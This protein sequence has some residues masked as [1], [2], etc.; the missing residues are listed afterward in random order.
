VKATQNNA[1]SPSSVRGALATFRASLSFANGTSTP[2]KRH[3]ALP[4]ALLT[5]L[6]LLA[7]SASSAQAVVT[8]EFLCQITGAGSATI[9]ATECDANPN[10]AENPPVL[11]GPLS[12]V[13]ALTVDSGTLW[14][15]EHLEGTGNYRVDEFNASSGAFV[16]QLAQS[17]NEELLKGIA[18]GH[19][20]GAAQL[21][22]GSRGSGVAV[23]DESGSRLATWTG[24][25]TPSGSIEKRLDVAVDSST[26]LADWAAGDVY[27]SSASESSGA[28]GVVDVFKPKPGGGEEYVSQL[29]GIEPGVPFSGPTHVTVDESNGDVFVLDERSAVDVF[30]PTAPGEYAFLRQ[31]I[32]TPAGPLAA[33]T[34]LA[35]DGGNG[36]LYLAQENGLLLQFDSAGNYLGQLSG[37]G[38]TAVVVDPATHRLYVTNSHGNPA[39]GSLN[40][41]VVNV[42]GPNIVV[43]D[44]ETEPASL[45]EPQEA[46]LNGTVN[47][48]SAGPATCRFAWGLT[49]ALNEPPLPCEAAVP[50][51]NTPQPVAA[52]LT[53]LQPG[54]TYFYRLQAENSAEVLNEG[55][56]SQTRQFTTAGPGIHS[57]SVSA[58]TA[59]SATLEAT[60][61]PNNTP[62]T[63]YFQY[64]ADTSY[65]TDVPAPP[66]ASLASGKGDV[67]V[68]RHLQ[69]LLAGTTYHYRVVAV[70]ELSPGHFETF[71]GPDH[72]FTTQLTTV[73]PILPDGRAWELVSPPD[74]H[75]VLLEG[76]NLDAA[77][78]AAAD[79]DAMTYFAAGA[80]ESE[81]QGY[82][83]GSQV[84]SRR[85]T[86]GWSSA[87]IGTSHRQAVGPGG[88]RRTGESLLFSE[89]LSRSLVEPHGPFSPP[90]ACTAT[91][92]L[93][94]AFPE[95]TE[96]TPYIHHDSSCAAELSTC[97][98]PLLTAA[99][100]YSDVPPGTKLFNPVDSENE[101]L[102][103]APDLNSVV[104]A[105]HAGLTLGASQEKELYEW[106]AA[107][108]PAE[109]LQLI[110]VLPQ[111]EGGGPASGG[112]QLG[113]GEAISAAGGW[114]PVSADGSRVFWSLSGALYMRDTGKGETIRL[115]SS[116][117]ATFQAASRDG[118]R[119]FFTEAGRL[120]LC[121]IV[122][123]GGKDVCKLAD[124]TPEANGESVNIQQLMPG[125]SADGSYAYFVGGLNLYVS[126]YDGTEWTTKLI[127]MLSQT[128]E[129]DWDNEGGGFLSFGG[130]TA[131]VS[132]NGRYLAFM[133]NRSLTGYD[134]RDA[135]TGRP[136]E[137]VYLYDGRAERLICASCNPT[138]ARPLGVE[139]GKA[140]SGSAAFS[141]LVDIQGIIPG[142]A[143][144]TEQTGIAANLPGG[145]TIEAYRG[146]L[147]Q[148][149]YLSDSG[150]LFF[151]SSDAL[152]PSDTNRNEDVYEYEPPGV[153]DC[154]EESPAYG[155]R[156][157]GCLG[158]IS[159]GASGEESGFLDASENGDDVFFL[160]SA[161][162]TKQDLDTS[163]DVYDAHVCTPESP[164]P[165]SPPPPPPV[166]EGDACQP[167]AEAPNGPTPGSLTFHGAGNVHEK[168]TT[169]T[170]GKVRKHGKCVAK[171]QKAKKHQV[172]HKKRHAHRAKSNRSAAR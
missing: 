25:D 6:L 49:A 11:G 144:Y 1:S 12:G 35:V 3:F 114:R 60:I 96:F 168:S 135:L 157:E 89:D 23:F 63:F 32:A 93:P 154:T 84:L 171:K 72:A 122:E 41:G 70:S 43:P 80:T 34:A 45:L 132:P 99:S 29:T 163:L 115:D 123:E 105:S 131:R 14:L 64:G 42:Y 66:G 69:G 102:G 40:E 81:P 24:A 67:E 61:D 152:L 100:G 112:P 142:H 129:H 95:P 46:T 59:E 71:D 73:G 16:S 62:T 86:S 48:D 143:A 22:V 10:P 78:Q 21:Y 4:L 169:C 54:T 15:A 52:K 167:P 58:V 20:T 31:I 138:G 28:G 92:C 30:E 103:A 124:L 97:Y 126:H 161:Q 113:G 166:C 33:V 162:L 87:S 47:P 39:G 128:D 94:V 125:T 2:S 38:H 153:G 101:F 36:D 18:V 27:V 121:E 116:G 17:S 120:H 146:S 127:A 119:I 130:L 147:Y 155:Q 109:R 5:G 136:D 150:R 104:L 9:S 26:N 65:G 55:E 107:A 151:N 19:A 159:S 91:G 44:V 140:I 37:A 82:G 165:P 57:T 160:T 8:H 56:P 141:N 106:S 53:G 148:P 117:G 137:E 83:E 76:L 51:A 77:E 111:G 108:P 149:R 133:S 79:G 88:G 7:L 13:D 68:S 164:C 98:E 85:G 172:G 170:E 75:G 139:V 158:L 156:S 74:K 134:N 50:D 118:S 110:S 145:V 90:T